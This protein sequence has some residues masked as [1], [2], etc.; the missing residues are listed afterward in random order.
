[1]HSVVKQ[2]DPS[3]T[4]DVASRSV[5]QRKHRL[6]DHNEKKTRLNTLRKMENSCIYLAR[7][8]HDN[9]FNALGEFDTT[10]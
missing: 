9:N 4:F 5:I 7:K 8:M 10:T 2:K 6:A 3:V 1:M